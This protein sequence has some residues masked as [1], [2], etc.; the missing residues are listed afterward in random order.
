MLIDI[1]DSDI[2][3]IALCQGS[4][5]IAQENIAVDFW[6]VCLATPGCADAAILISLTDFVDDD[7]QNPPDLRGQLGGADRAGF[8]P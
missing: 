3:D 4:G 6:C 7:R 1:F 5:H 8:F 2:D